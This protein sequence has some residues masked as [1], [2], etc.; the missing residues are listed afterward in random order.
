[1]QYAVIKHADVDSL[2]RHVNAL[3]ADG[4]APLGGVAVVTDPRADAAQPVVY[5]QA[6]QSPD[7][8]EAHLRRIARQ[9][10]SYSGLRRV[11]R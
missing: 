1:M 9:I 2:C 3:I 7:P 5:C 10:D 6:M 11:D 8:Q 4:W